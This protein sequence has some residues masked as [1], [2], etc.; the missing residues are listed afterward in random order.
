MAYTD[1][2]PAGGLLEVLGLGWLAKEHII[3]GQ[4][5]QMLKVEYELPSEADRELFAVE[6]KKFSEWANEQGLRSLP[7]SGH[8]A[9]AYLVDLVLGGA[10][11]DKVA[12]AAAAIKFAHEMAC[13]FLDWAPIQAALDFCCE[14][15]Q[16]Q[17]G[18][19]S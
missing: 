7:A 18:G 6:L 4:I 2:A 11:L 13:Q 19:Q 16:S 12:A 15:N 14:H 8:V 10:S 1:C 9:A 5:E 3:T 17:L